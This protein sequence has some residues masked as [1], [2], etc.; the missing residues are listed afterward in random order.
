M[1]RQEL[2]IGSYHRACRRAADRLGGR[3][4]IFS[5]RHGLLP[6]DRVIEP[7]ELAMGRLGSVTVKVL[8]E[9]AQELDVACLARAG[10]TVVHRVS[11]TRPVRRAGAPPRRRGP[12]SVNAKLKAPLAMS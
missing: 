12:R 9:Q 11:E 7:Y 3:L 8:R 5:A 2:Y 10:R 1:E 4:L 6:P